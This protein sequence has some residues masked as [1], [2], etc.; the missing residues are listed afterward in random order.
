MRQ[1]AEFLF[2]KFVV[3]EIVIGQIEAI[4]G[5]VLFPGFSGGF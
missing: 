5:L 1:L 3:V 2:D 4:A